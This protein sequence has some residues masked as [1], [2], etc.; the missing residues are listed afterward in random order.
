MN[1]VTGCSGID[2]IAYAAML[3]DIEV[4]G[5]IEIDD[6]C[7][8]I[9]ELRFPGV[10]RLKDVFD[11]R[12]DEFG[13]VDIF[14]AGIPCQPFSHAGKREGTEDDRYLWSEAIRIIRVMQ[15]S[16]V[17][18]EN[19]DGI[20]SMEQSDSETVMEAE[21]DVCTEA[22]M[23]LETIRK[24]LEKTGYQSIPI[25]IPAAGV[26]APHQRYRYFI[27][28]FAK[29]ER[30]E[31]WIAKFSGAGIMGHSQSNGR[32]SRRA[33]SAGLSGESWA[34]GTGGATL[35]YAESQRCGNGHDGADKRQTD[36]E[37]NSPTNKGDGCGTTLGNTIGGGCDREPRRGTGTEPA[38][39]YSGIEAKANT[40]GK[41]L[42]GGRY[43]WGRRGGLADSSTIMAN[44]ASIRCESYRELATGE[45]VGQKEERTYITESSSW[46]AQS[47]LGGNADGLPGWL[48][49]PG[50]HEDGS[51]VFTAF[52]AIFTATLGQILWPA[53][54][55][56]EQY[57]YEPPRVATGIK[58][59]V[60]RLKA[61]GNSIVWQQIFPFLLAIKLLSAPVLLF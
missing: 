48:H 14:A 29:T 32:D 30:Q 22:E 34:S 55:G 61:L 27:V 35:V 58:H 15:P 21:A 43:S 31:R 39:G 41:F 60:N 42:Y 47:G 54:Y 45:R 23:V 33:E 44:T 3:L 50:G 49:K 37:I 59:R 28:A 25:V 18:I 46:S 40:E 26:E 51:G 5:Q 56:A 4:V 10:K 24:D 16:W 38:D 2:A 9:L 13:T 11:V 12:G 52:E 6:F 1:I 53:G 7:N 36:R 8:Q 57:N 19:V 20:G 17:I